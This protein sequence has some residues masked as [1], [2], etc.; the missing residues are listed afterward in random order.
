MPYCRRG[1]IYFA[2]IFLATG[3]PCLAGTPTPTGTM[4]DLQPVTMVDIT[5][6]PV[7]YQG[8]TLSDIGMK[9]IAYEGPQRNDFTVSPIQ[10]SDKTL[11]IAHKPTLEQANTPSAMSTSIAFVPKLIPGVQPG[12]KILS[13][14]PGRTMA[15]NPARHDGIGPPRW[16]NPNHGSPSG[17]SQIRPV[18]VEGVDK[19]LEYAT[20][21]R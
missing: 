21:H 13:P 5:V 17:L 9:R 1:L 11:T 16:H 18:A 8:P 12:L 15:R 19:G 10:F 20:S 14:K 6:A 3:M 4:P 7:A 2:L